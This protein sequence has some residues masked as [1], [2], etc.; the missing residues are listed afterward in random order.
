MDSHLRA[1]IAVYNSGEYHAAHD[2]WEERWLDLE[3]DT[4]D[5][6]FLHG[7]IQFTAAVYHGHQGNRAGLQG[8]AESAGTYLEGLASPYR[9]V[10]LGPVRGYLADLATDPERFEGVDAPAL[11]HR[12]RAPHL[13][14][15]ADAGDFEAVA[16]AAEVLA[17][18]YEAYDEDAVGDAIDYASD[19]V[20]VNESGRFV[21]LV[22]DFVA[23]ER[24]D[25][26]H[27]RLCEH[28]RRRRSREEDVTGLFDPE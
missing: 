13:S 15:L 9:G 28:V 17:E 20:E 8:L 26:V 7:L 27:Q 18:E 19:S 23:G 12:G 2:A 21:A 11:T 24:R 16:I 1:G 10:D 3:S 5:E 4:P 25:L 6:Q 22:F 14:D